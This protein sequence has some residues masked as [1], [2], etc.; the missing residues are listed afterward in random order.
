VHGK[1]G[2][3]E[4]SISAPTTVAEVNGGEVCSIRIYTRRA[5]VLGVIP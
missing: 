5:W 4:V 2:I 3:D 1:D